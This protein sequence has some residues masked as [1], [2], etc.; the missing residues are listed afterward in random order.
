MNLLEIKTRANKLGQEASK[1]NLPRVP[2]HDARVMDL[3]RECS[4]LDKENSTKLTIQMLDAWH[5][6]YQQICNIEANKILEGLS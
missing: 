5:A 1:K 6:G 4:K 2:A 3:V